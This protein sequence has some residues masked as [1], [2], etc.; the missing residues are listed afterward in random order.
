MLACMHNLHGTM[1][2][3]TSAGVL[4]PAQLLATTLILYSWLCS[5]GISMV[6][7]GVIIIL[8]LDP[9]SVGETVMM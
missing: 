6:V 5:T 7:L 1:S 2:I 4:F 9:A 8:D 3:M